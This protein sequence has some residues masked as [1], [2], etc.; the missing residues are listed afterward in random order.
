MPSQQKK[1]SLMQNGN[2]DTDKI[3]KALLRLLHCVEIDDR[4]GPLQS[5]LAA[6]KDMPGNWIISS[7]F[8]TCNLHGACYPL[9]PIGS[10]C[11]SL[12]CG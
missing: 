4:Q 1:L 12:H 2:L 9:P 11:S 5:Q 8:A 10:P 3:L 6:H 7:G